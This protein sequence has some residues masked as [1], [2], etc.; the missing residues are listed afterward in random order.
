MSFRAAALLCSVVL[1]ACGD[2]SRILGVVGEPD[3]ATIRFVNMSG[4]TLD[5][6]V[7]GSTITGNANVVSGTA[8]GCFAI[9]NPASPGL[10]V[11]ATGTSTDLP[12]LAPVFSSNGSYAV[13]AYPG[14]TGGVLFATIPNASIITAGRSALRVFNGIPTVSSADVYVTTPGTPFGFPRETGLLFGRAS[15]SFDVPAGSN[16]VRL[17]SAGPVITEVGTHVLDAGKSYTLIVSSGAS[18]LLVPD[19]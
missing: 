12:G 16:Q 10:S 1:A 14:A 17:I 2:G 5:F 18:P 3:A 11:R 9:P 13:L 15:G 8:L 19:C 7:G 6:L 4:S